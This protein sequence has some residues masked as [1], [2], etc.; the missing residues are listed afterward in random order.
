MESLNI[1]IIYYLLS[2][3]IAF[4]LTNKSVPLLNKLGEKYKLIDIP[5][6][7][8]MHKISKTRIGGVSILFGLFSSLIIS[9]SLVY[10]FHGLYFS[11]IIV[12]MIASFL[13]FS[14]GFIDDIFNISPW[15]RLLI[16]ILISSLIWLFYLRIYSLEFS[17]LS[18]FSYQLILPLL[19]SYVFSIVWISG[20]INAFNW[21]DGIDG[22][23]ILL[24]IIAS[25]FFLISSFRTD[26]FGLNLLIF[27][28]LGS[29][30]GFLRF[31]T[32]PS[33]I[34]MG[35]CGSYFLGFNIAI[36]S[37]IFCS[38]KYFLYE[39]L[40]Q[41]N[42]NI[43]GSIFILAVPLFD[44]T[45]VI[46]KRTIK[47]NS[48]FFPDQSHLHH[49]LARKGFNQKDAVRIICFISTIFSIFSLIFFY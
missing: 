38:N 46:A 8:S 30:F 35:D 41:L 43:I 25:I 1:Q 40:N 3:F 44:M 22:L 34:L 21:M 37:L 42:S 47:G 32:Y 48:P 29:C 5:N 12:L 14:L 18:I 20:V 15:P 2:I 16:Q 6:E 27:S 28:L 9:L 36:I 11:F 7:R 45:Y 24:T 17:F 31:N 39:N 13:I 33:K 49:R 10:I 4:F 26:F 19:L 23:A